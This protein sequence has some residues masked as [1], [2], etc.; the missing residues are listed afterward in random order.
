MLERAPIGTYIQSS[1]SYMDCLSSNV[2]VKCIIDKQDTVHYKELHGRWVD[3]NHH[4]PFATDCNIVALFG[5][6]SI[7]P[8]R[9]VT[10]TTNK[11]LFTDNAG[12]DSNDWCRD[13]CRDWW[14]RASVLAENGIDLSILIKGS[15]FTTLAHLNHP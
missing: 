14:C 9:C 10:P 4:S 5:K 2:D 12:G 1:R 7:R 3:I 8:L 6:N 11:A 13:W 15:I